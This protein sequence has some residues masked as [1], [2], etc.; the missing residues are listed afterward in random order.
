MLGLRGSGTLSSCP[1]CPKDMAFPVAITGEEEAQC[2]HTASD[3]V[4]FLTC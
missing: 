2:S 1:H 3:Q 4:V